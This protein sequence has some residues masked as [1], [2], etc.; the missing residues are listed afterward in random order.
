MIELCMRVLGERA[1]GGPV[2]IRTKDPRY[3]ARYYAFAVGMT[4][5]TSQSRDI[6]KYKYG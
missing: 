6:R 2:L 3:A 4:K 5:K 1:E